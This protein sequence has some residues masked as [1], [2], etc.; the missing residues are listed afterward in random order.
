MIVTF[1]TG[2]NELIPCSLWI[3]ITFNHL[4]LISL[5]VFLYLFRVEGKVLKH[6]FRCVKVMH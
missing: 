5:D 4:E 2:R 1:S 6:G 3:L